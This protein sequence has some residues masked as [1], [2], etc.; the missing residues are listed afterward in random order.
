M[1]VYKRKN[2]ETS[3]WMI[4]FLYIHPVSGVEERY[5]RAHKEV[6]SK[7]MALALEREIRARLTTPPTKAEE[8]VKD[9]L[10][11]DF[12]Q[13]WQATRQAD[14]K[15]TARRGYEQILRVHLVPWFA[16]RSL[17]SIGVEDVQKY[18]AAKLSGSKAS[19]K[20]RDLSPKTVN[21]HLGVLSS[22]FEDAVKW[23]YAGLN[24]ARQVKPCRSDRTVE[25]FDYWS[26]AESERFLGAVQRVRPRWFPF[27]LTALRTGLRMGELA[28]LRWEDV[29]LSRARINVRRSF[30]HGAETLPKSGRGRTLPM[31]EQLLTVLTEHR[32][33]NPRKTQVFVSDDGALLDSNRVKRAFWAGIK[34]ARVKRI[35]IHD[36]RHS[37]AS[38]LVAAGVSLF[39]VQAL[40]GHQDAKMTMRYAHL[41]PEAQVDAVLVL[42]APSKNSAARLWHAGQIGG[43]Q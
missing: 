4:D 33:Q 15:P 28:A 42:D 24:P 18:K 8:A 10:F 5:R 26:S 40:L 14:W 25:D 43:V 22:L 9:A 19:P 39:K 35:R 20:T 32:R 1:S 6:A 36:L 27:F 16:G 13:Q 17:R 11:N 31:S 21:N 3:T 37:F 7:A 2:K 34:A 41:S 29:D 38:Q 30:S 12:A 23:R